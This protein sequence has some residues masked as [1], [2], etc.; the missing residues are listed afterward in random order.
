MIFS[1]IL[2]FHARVLTEIIHSFF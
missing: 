2:K 1:F